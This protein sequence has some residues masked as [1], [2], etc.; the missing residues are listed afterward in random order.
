VAKYYWNNNIE[1]LELGNLD[2]WRDEGH[3]FDYVRAMH[4]ILQQDKPDDY[5]VAM[6]I[7]TKIRTWVEKCFEYIDKRIEWEGVGIDEVGRCDGKVVITINPKY[8][9]PSEVFRLLGNPAKIKS[10]G[11]QPKYTT[12][13]LLKE[14]MDFD[15]REQKRI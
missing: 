14:M 2:S 7:T 9:R 13:M 1:P 8:F 11:W 4:L 15:I 5:V 6:G 12:D 3:S 10:L